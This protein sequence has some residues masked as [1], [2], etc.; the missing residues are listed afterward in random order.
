[1]QRH[2]GEAKVMLVNIGIDID[3]QARAKARRHRLLLDNG[4]LVN[5][6]QPIVN[7]RTGELESVEILCRLQDGNQIIPPSEFLAGFGLTELD[8]L[9]F[10]SLEAGILTLQ[11]CRLSH[12]A[13]KMSV[14]VH[15]AVLTHDGFAG[16]LIA[17][18]REQQMDPR[19]ITLEIL[20]GDD[21]LNIESAFAEIQILRAAGIQIA[22]D[23]VGS[24]YSSLKR[25]RELPVDSFKLDQAFVRGLL[26]QPDD[27]QFVASMISLARGLRKKLVVEGVENSDI[28]NALQVLGV[29]LAQGYAIARP[30]PTDVLRYWMASRSETRCSREVRCMLGAYAAHLRIVE[31]CHMLMDGTVEMS[32]P[33][34]LQDPHICAI[35]HFFDQN[36]LHQTALGIAHILFHMSIKNHHAGAEDW[37]GSAEDLRLALEA[38]VVRGPDFLVATS[39]GR[40]SCHDAACMKTHLG[41]RN[42]RCGCQLPFPTLTSSSIIN[43]PVSASS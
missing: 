27:L 6:Y 16:R 40:L 34:A 4:G 2:Q 23:D 10:L 28:A 12:P 25:L 11:A 21:F 14:N 39:E 8:T 1:M 26:Q 32:L 35:G 20:E 9:L 18:L 42:G 29:G 7:L 41:V 31:T 19:R 38:A 15:T 37:Q 22:L 5:H 13:L 3:R 30:M 43:Q 24:G 17:A 33:A 36:D